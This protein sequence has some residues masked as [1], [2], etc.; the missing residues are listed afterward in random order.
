MSSS[1]IDRP[2]IYRGAA[3]A[4]LMQWSM[5]VIGLV[6]VLILARLLTPH[7]FGI[8]G[9]AMAAVA[10]VEILGQVGLYQ[11]L[12]RIEKPER[13]HLDT[14]WTIQLILFFAMGVVTIALAPIAAWAYDKPVLA[15]VIAALAT[16]FFFFALYNIGIV[17]FERHFQ[18]GRDM[19]MRLSARLGSFVI[20]VAAALLLRSH[21]ALVIGLVS[22]SAL[23]AA[24]SY[25]AHPYRPRLSLACRAELLGVSIWMMVESVA[26]TMQQQ[27]ERLV[28]GAFGSAHLVGLYSVSKDLSEIFTQEIAT[29]LN[30]VTFV[31]VARTGPLPENAMRTAT[32]LGA[33]AM[34]AAPMGFGLAAAA[35]PAVLVLLGDQWAAAVPF[36]RV[37]AVYSALF[38]VYK[39][40]ASSL[41]A[42]GYIRL[43]AGLS[44]S[45][46]A[47]SA[48]AALVA[49]LLDPAALSIAWAVFGATLALLTAG[50]VTIARL[51]DANW[52]RFAVHVAR[53]FAAAGA[54][55]ALVAYAV[56]DLGSALPDLAA[57]V[58]TGVIAYPLILLAIWVI[59]GRPHGAEAEA[60]GLLGQ[61]RARLASA[62]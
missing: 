39:V 42:A 59:S 17:D 51:S 12:L 14:A 52:L 48:L 18:F 58:A 31:T 9:L 60:L 62:S 7:D 24:G 23:M 8:I 16:R 46:A 37:I 5:R 47:A 25:I 53:P 41:Q 40:I 29:A 2:A 32:I 21:W 36:L 34:I 6:S 11:A 4:V 3:L 38:A 30:R 45:G 1:P 13:A 22:Q 56:P 54:M 28:I 57:R 26:L 15:W 19:K 33:Y 50:L 43:V 20:T 35:E 61:L 27:V 49:A 10:L 55:C 44:G